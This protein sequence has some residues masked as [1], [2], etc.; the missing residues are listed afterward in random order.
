MIIKI[1]NYC[2]KFTPCPRSSAAMA[3]H[4]LVEYANELSLLPYIS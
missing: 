3:M 2:N 1:S 4:H